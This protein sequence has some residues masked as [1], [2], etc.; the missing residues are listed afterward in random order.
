[1]FPGDRREEGY[2]TGDRQSEG[3]ILSC[4]RVEGPSLCGTAATAGRCMGLASFLRHG[5]TRSCVRQE[6]VFT[7]SVRGH[8]TLGYHKGAGV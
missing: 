2:A 3:C 8:L 6:D 7:N 5:G 4:T 1:M